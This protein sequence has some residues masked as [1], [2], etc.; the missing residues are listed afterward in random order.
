MVTRH[1][2]FSRFQGRD[3]IDFSR[4]EGKIRLPMILQ[5]PT[6]KTD[7]KYLSD[8]KSNTIVERMENNVLKWQGHVVRME[9]DRWPK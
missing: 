4:T 8:I 5:E 6:E 1:C 2:L 3:V 7:S 9:G